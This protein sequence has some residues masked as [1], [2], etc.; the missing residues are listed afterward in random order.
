MTKRI[1][2]ALSVTGCAAGAVAALVVA[3]TPDRV[4]P[5]N[6]SVGPAPCDG[7][8]PGNFPSPTCDPSDNSC[9]ATDGVCNI[10]TQKCGDPN[11]CL[12]MA[13]NTGKTTLDMRLR[14][15]FLTAPASLTSAVIQDSVVTK[16]IDLKAPECGDPS[17]DGSFNWLV[18]ID[19]S[20]GMVTTGGA[21]PSSDPFG[22]GF[23]FFRKQVGTLDVKPEQAK[24]TFDS[25]GNTFTS[26][27]IPLLNVPVFVGGD[28]NAIIVL[29]IRDAVLQ[30]AT[31]S[32]DGNCIGSFNSKAL[33]SSCVVSD[34]GSCTK[35]HTAGAI[36]G[37]MTLEDADQVDVSV[38]S[39]SL[40]VVLTKTAKGPDNKCM[41]DT[42]GNIA[43]TGDFCSTTK[44][45]GGCADSFW[46][47]AAFAAAAVKIN[48]G[49]A[50]PNCQ[51]G[52]VDGG[53]DSGAD[54]G[55]DGGAD[56]G[57]AGAADAAGE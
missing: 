25:T 17:G 54:A 50:D 35:W 42:N 55:A 38:L 30:S 13:D 24:I 52:A 18:R 9:P 49:S 4:R 19:K 14:R 39:S 33:T 47:S 57:D 27:T 43:A 2:L 12:P 6:P 10:D 8:G 44:T 5:Y 48:D 20:A 21:P 22:Q 56:A 1:L 11:T 15:L 26:D 51:A 23:C 37:Y 36:G 41:R 40:C 31:L 46:L 53:S 34:P 28:I 29:P 3:C 7:G 32:S 45:P 16:G